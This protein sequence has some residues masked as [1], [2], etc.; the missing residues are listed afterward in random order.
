MDEQK[1][2]KEQKKRYRQ[3]HQEQIKEYNAERYRL[4]KD[5]MLA[6]QKQYRKEIK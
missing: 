5:E 1:D 2:R 6:H 3:E 4:Y